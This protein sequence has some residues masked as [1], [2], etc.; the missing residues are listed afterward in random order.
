MT[1]VIIAYSFS[2]YDDV[3]AYLPSAWFVQA[4]P[5][6]KL[7]YMVARA[8]P[9]NIVS[10]QVP[11]DETPHAKLLEICHSLNLTSLEVKFDSKGKRKRSL[12]QSFTD[13]TIRGVITSFIERKVRQFL[14]TLLAADLPFCLD[15]ERKVVLE[16]IRIHP[17]VEAL[18]PQL[19]F[20][21][22]EKGIEYSL[23]L[24][25]KD[26]ITFPSDHDVHIL[27]NEPGYVVLDYKLYKLDLINGNKIKPFQSKRTVFIPER[28]TK[29]YFQKFVVDVV[30]LVDVEANGFEITQFDSLKSISAICVEDFMQDRYVL[31]LKLHYGETFFLASDRTQR[32]NRLH[33]EGDNIRIHQI[34]RGKEE[35][36]YFEQI[37]ALGLCRNEAGRFELPK[38]V[39]DKYGIFHWLIDHQDELD[40]MG[41][42]TET[43]EITGKP[44]LLSKA[45]LH[46]DSTADNDWF[47]IHGTIVIGEHT[48]YFSDLI[49]AIRQGNPLW[50]LPD[51]QIFVIPDPWMS[52]YSSLATFGQQHDDRIRIKK[53][54]YSLVEE[55]EDLSDG[56][57]RIVVDHEEV[58]Y[59]PSPL[60]KA[61]LRP[62]QTEGIKW[63]LKHQLNGLGA[64]LADDMGLGKTLQTLAVLCHTKEH[65]SKTELESVPG[66]P[67]LDLFAS[68]THSI[69]SMLHALVILPASL[70]FNWVEEL[71]KFT[72]HLLVCQYVGVD[73]HKE[74]IEQFDVVITTYQ[75]ALR[76]IEHLCT[77]EWDYVIL[78]ESHM[79]KNKESKIFKAVSSLI[80]ENKISLSGT[81]IENSLSDL[82]S[83]MQFINPDI[84]G[85]FSFFKKHFLVPIQK[86]ESTSA[87]AELRRLVEPFILRRRKHEVAKDLP[88]LFEQVEMVPM[89]ESQTDLFEKEKSAARNYLLGM[90]ESDPEFRFHVFR[91]LL[92][93]RQIANHPVLLDDSSHCDSG[94]FE[95]IISDIVSITKSNQKVLIFSSFT[96]HLGLVAKELEELKIQ[97]SILTG[98][99][100]QKNRQ[101][102]V[103]QFQE[104]EASQ[105]FLISIKAGGVG[106][107][108]TKAD[109]IFILD[110]WWNPFVEQQAVARSHRI[111]RDRPI[112]VFRYISKGTIEEKII[113]LQA[114]KKVLAAEI[115]ETEQQISLAKEDLQFL[116][117]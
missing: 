39:K 88:E 46:I 28:I 115:L 104:N 37:M 98:S 70:V 42:R 52:K 85:S 100:T 4:T 3:K 2:Y 22:N 75:T 69:N 24:L 21:K 66:I 9:E 74:D 55:D 114:R 99:T 18:V 80:A 44:I 23:S 54:Q 86:Y 58:E 92:R 35:I 113:K 43:P 72:P 91:S 79:I 50:E 83:Q 94:K 110:P 64:C 116:L 117:S 73:R 30:N 45:S 26:E 97:Y 111:G 62:Y 11:V 84:L 36:K 27:L 7:G 87:L 67:Q 101:K 77:L 81:P 89:S 33:F 5:E 48:L 108:L 78:D 82:W 109:Y 93:L 8:V 65:K 31:D 51:G 112:H 17:Q 61:T 68:D 19:S 13:E 90:E 57:L 20:N 76:D 10:Y 6:Q 53:S 40:K 38:E 71:H 47:D 107:N 32:R 95:R 106:L 56:L 63:L 60:L 59:T 103:K 96:S 14:D 41:I 29:T 49:Q 12:K 25:R 102:A 1:D 105:V 16:H 15:I 34:K